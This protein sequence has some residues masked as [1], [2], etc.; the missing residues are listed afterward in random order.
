LIKT[1]DWQSFRV[2]DMAVFAFFLPP[3]FTGQDKTIGLQGRAVVSRID[4]ENQGIGVEF[5]R[6]FRLFEL[7]D[8]PNA[9]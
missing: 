8:V 7:V 3:R 1:K 4:K 6:D 2:Q 5:V 9:A